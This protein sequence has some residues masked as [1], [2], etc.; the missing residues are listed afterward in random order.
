MEGESDMERIGFGMLAALGGAAII[1]GLLL[2]SGGKRPLGLGL[3]AAG[4]VAVSVAWDW[5]ALFTVPIGIVLFA[6]A[7]FRGQGT[8]SPRIAKS[9]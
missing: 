2:S 9:S 8:A 6:V 7:Y 4:V 1:S 5:V 3:I